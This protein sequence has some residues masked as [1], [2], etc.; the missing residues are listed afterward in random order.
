MAA[1]DDVL[2]QIAALDEQERAEF[3]QVMRRCADTFA[4]MRAGGRTAQTLRTAAR[5]VTLST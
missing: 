1:A 4:G 3:A 2:A 5:L